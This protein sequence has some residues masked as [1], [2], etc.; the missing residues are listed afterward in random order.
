MNV[1]MPPAELFDSPKGAPIIDSE[2]RVTL[3]PGFCIFNG[4]VFES[5]EELMAW[6]EA[7]LR[8]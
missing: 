7:R 6:Q 4:M 3:E 8:A 1:P 2:L 5:I